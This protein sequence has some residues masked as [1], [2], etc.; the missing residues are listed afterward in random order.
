MKENNKE[1]KQKKVILTMLSA[2]IVLGAIATVVLVQ[3]FK[4]IEILEEINKAGIEWYKESGETFTIKTVDELYDLAFLSDFYDFKGQTIKL[5]ADLVINEGNASD[6][7]QTP[8]ERQWFP[9]QGFAV[10]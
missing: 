7:E 4:K 9:I 8:P 5:G 2:L 1:R 6:W 10:L 3:R